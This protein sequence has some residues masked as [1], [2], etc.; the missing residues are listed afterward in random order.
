MN[1][2][3][4]GSTF[5]SGFL[6]LSDSVFAKMVSNKKSNKSPKPP[7]IPFL[8][9]IPTNIALGPLGFRADLDIDSNSGDPFSIRGGVT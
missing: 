6:F 4:C 9:G 7:P 5:P 8:L 2:A 1:L 3:G